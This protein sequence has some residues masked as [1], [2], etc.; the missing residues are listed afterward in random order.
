MIVVQGMTCQDLSLRQLK[1]KP[2]VGH[3]GCITC[4]AC[5]GQRPKA[6]VIGWRVRL[7]QFQRLILF[8]LTVNGSCLQLWS[9][10]SIGATFDAGPV[11]GFSLFAPEGHVLSSFT[12]IQMA[13][14]QPTRSRAARVD[15]VMVLIIAVSQACRLT[16]P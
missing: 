14:R 4:R 5:V 16:M 2:Q 8:P 13:R 15:D 12:F 10:S 11:T 7:W 3:I 1:I 9:W 6:D